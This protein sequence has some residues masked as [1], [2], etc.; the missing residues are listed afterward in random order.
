MPRSRQSSRGY[1]R[2]ERRLTAWSLGPGGDDILFDPAAPS[3]TSNGVF[4]S[5]VTPV[6]PQLTVVRIRG[7]FTALLKT[8]DA[9]NAGFTGAVGIGI[10]S[11]DAFAIGITAI[12][13]P[14]S[15]AE[16][17]GWL[18]HQFFDLTASFALAANTTQPPSIRIPVETKAMRKLRLNEILF[19]NFEVGET[20]AAT[21]RMTFVSRMLVK[22]P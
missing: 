3:A 19:A 20:A 1:A 12:P 9:A 5:G 4:G 14:F 15:D 16:W 18:W 7:M 10:V 22:L 13:K 21:L 11:A 8:A 2:A 17:P 6:I